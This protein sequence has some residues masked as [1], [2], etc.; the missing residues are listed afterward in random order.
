MKL[1]SVHYI[2]LDE[3]PVPIGRDQFSDATYNSSRSIAH[4]PRY[5]ASHS[6]HRHRESKSGYRSDS[7]LIQVPNSIYLQRQNRHP[8]QALIENKKRRSSV[9]MN[10]FGGYARLDNSFGVQS[11]T[12]QMTERI[13][14]GGEH[15]MF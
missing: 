4:A 13:F 10:N 14:T 12:G 9:V 5:T 6:Q 11:A 15:L 8:K 3:R 1:F 7:E 2:F